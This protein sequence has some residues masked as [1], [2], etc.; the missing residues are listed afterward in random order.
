MTMQMTCVSENQRELLVIQREHGESQWHGSWSCVEDPQPDSVGMEIDLDE[1]MEVMQFVFDNT[2][3]TI[4]IRFEGVHASFFYCIQHLLARQ[5]QQFPDLRNLW[6]LFNVQ[7]S[8]FSSEISEA[9][10]HPDD[11]QFIP[12]TRDVGD[13]EKTWMVV[14]RSGLEPG[15]TVIESAS[16]SANATSNEPDLTGKFVMD[17]PTTLQ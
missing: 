6:K 16:A 15:F 14:S 17:A 12:I 1:I 7:G 2:S 3:T 11:V 8:G 10:D 13:L 9:Y 5:E 4:S